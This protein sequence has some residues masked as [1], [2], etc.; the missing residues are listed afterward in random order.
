MSRKLESKTHC[1]NCGEKLDEN[2]WVLK[3]GYLQKRCKICFN[4]HSNTHPSRTK[5]SRKIQWIA[6][7]HGMIIQEYNKKL[8]LQLNGCAICKQPCKTGRQ[9]AIDHNHKTGKRRDLLCFRCNSVIGKLNEDEDLIW[10]ILEYL[11]RHNNEEKK[12]S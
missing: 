8:E 4:A 12:I 9:L 5:E 1:I 6:W 2:N 7:Q 3:S 10:N 11:K